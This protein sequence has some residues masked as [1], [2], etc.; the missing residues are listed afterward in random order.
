MSPTETEAELERIARLIARDLEGRT[1][2]K[3][4]AL[5]RFTLRG[6]DYDTTIGAIA[7]GVR[8]GLLREEGGRLV[9]GVTD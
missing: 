4:D 7:Y 5:F 9:S 1:R 8:V 6:F 3:I 2:T